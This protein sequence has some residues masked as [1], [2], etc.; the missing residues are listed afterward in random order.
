MLN[1]RWPHR[2][3]M[4][5]GLLR[6]CTTSPINRFAALILIDSCVLCVMEHFSSVHTAAAPLDSII[7]EMKIWNNILS[8]LV[9]LL[10][11]ATSKSAYK[12][13]P[14]NENS[15]LSTLKTYLLLWPRPLEWIL[16]C[17]A[18]WLGSGTGHGISQAEEQILL[19]LVFFSPGRLMSFF[20]SSA[21][22][23]ILWRWR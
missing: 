21:P 2:L 11:P 20:C 22:C 13:N 15:G 6:D 12:C 14:G 23:S 1:G 4:W 3:S 16:L 10:H 17:T 5:R 19:Y 18:S 8:H 7:L 9:Q